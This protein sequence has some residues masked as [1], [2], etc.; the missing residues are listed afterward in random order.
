MKKFISLLLIFILTF[1]VSI[2]AKE[3]YITL[4]PYPFSSHTLGEDLVIYGD[5]S[6]SQVVLGFYYP[7][8]PGYKGY[9]K[10]I[11][12]ISA[13]EFRE[14]YTIQTETVSRFWPEGVWKIIIQNGEVRDE[15]LINMTSEPQFDRHIRFAEYTDNTLCNLQTYLCRGVEYRNNIITIPLENGD[16]IRIYSWKNFAPTDSGETQ[17]FIATYKDGYMTDIKFREGR[18]T[19]YG[20]HIALDISETERFEIFYWDDNLVPIS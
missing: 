5:T 19:D 9:A 12:T 11:I 20:N 1:P 13:K 2:S 16:E 10:Y 18:L 7:D 3:S 14:G 15:M 4:S 6:F 8:D 17:L